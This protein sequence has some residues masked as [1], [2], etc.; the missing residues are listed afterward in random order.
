MN[1]VYVVLEE[2]RGCGPSVAGV[3]ASLAAAQEYLAGPCGSNCYL[4]SSEGEEVRAV[5]VLSDEDQALFAGIE[6]NGAFT[7]DGAKDAFGINGFSDPCPDCGSQLKCAPGGGVKCSCGY[8][9]C[10]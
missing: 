8:W 5:P 9:F 6:S 7:I 3:F 4:D 1:K 2:D 10:Y